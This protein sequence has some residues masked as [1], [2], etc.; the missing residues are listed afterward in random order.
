[1]ELLISYYSAASGTYQ[2][3][4]EV[5][6]TSGFVN[7]AGTKAVSPFASLKVSTCMSSVRPLHHWPALATPMAHSPLGYGLALSCIRVCI[8]L[9]A[10]AEHLWRPRGDQHPG[11]RHR[12]AEWGLHFGPGLGVGLR[13]EYPRT[14]GVMP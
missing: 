14:L 3:N 8:S 6:T 11:L 4:L 5:S 1:M 10:A 9:A 7:V 12:G 13:C 2:T